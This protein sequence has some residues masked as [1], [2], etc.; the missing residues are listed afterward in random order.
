MVVNILGCYINAAICP[1]KSIR[2]DKRLEKIHILQRLENRISFN[3]WIEVE[4]TLLT[5]IEY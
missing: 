4:N 1:F 3:E 5:I 2:N